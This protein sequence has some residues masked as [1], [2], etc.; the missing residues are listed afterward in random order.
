MGRTDA[1]DPNRT[2]PAEASSGLDRGAAGALKTPNRS[3]AIT[4][5]EGPRLHFFHHVVTMGLDGAFCRAKLMSDL[6]VLLSPNYKL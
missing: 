1:S 3:A 6:L 5:S 4:S 2:Y